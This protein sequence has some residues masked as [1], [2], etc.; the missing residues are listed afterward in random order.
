MYKSKNGNNNNDDDN[1]KYRKNSSFI[2]KVHFLNYIGLG[3]QTSG[4]GCSQTQASFVNP[5]KQSFIHH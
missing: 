3:D 1:N 5:P 4:K 2:K